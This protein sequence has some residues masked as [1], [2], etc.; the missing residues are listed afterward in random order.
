MR[1][2]PGESRRMKRFENPEGTVQRITYWMDAGQ[3]IGARKSQEDSVAASYPEDE[4]ER[5]I[6]CVLSDGM[7]GLS[8]GKEASEAVVDSMISCFYDAKPDELPERILLKGCREAQRRVL[9]MQE[10]PREKG[11]TLTAALIR[12]ERCSFLSVGD[13]RI[14]LYRAGGLIQLTRDQNKRRRIETQV[15]LGTLPPEA[16][17][18]RTL[19]S[20][21]MFIG[22][23][24]LDR[25]DRSAQSFR[26]IPG[27]RLLLMS[28]GVFGALTVKEMAD[29]VR[30]ASMLA[31]RELIEQVLRK[32]V[33]NQDNCTVI[34]LGCETDWSAGAEA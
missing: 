4:R 19:R 31:A 33:P 7:G 6:L 27:D 16:R 11:A 20:L 24:E 25:I 29:I 30:N 34:V 18:D 26:L 28:D 23:E 15:G 32:G 2:E 17:T 22:R 13:S 14:Y 10:S 1:Q 12:K 5:G 9:A 21:S 8:D 3:D